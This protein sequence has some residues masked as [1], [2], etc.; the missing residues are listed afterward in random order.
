L[1]PLPQ[2]DRRDTLQQLSLKALRNRLPE[3][4]FL[5]RD[6]RIDDKGVDGALEVK[7]EYRVP[8]QGG[9]EEVRHQFTNC[10][11]QAQLKSTDKP[12]QNQDGSVSY[13]IETNNLNYLLNGPSPIYFLWIAPTDEVRYAWARDEWRRL[14]VENPEWKEQGECTVR[15]REILDARAVEAIHDRVI[16]EARL[17]RKIHETLARSS[18]AERVVV[19]INPQTLLS[20]DPQELFKWITAS[21]M[22]IVSSGYGKQVLLWL[23]VLDTARR[24][25]ARV[26]L[27]AAYAQAGLGRYHTAASH[28]AEAG[29]RRSSLSESDLRV[30]DYLR[31]VCR[32]QTGGMDRAEYVRREQG[33]AAQRTGTPAAE[34]LM[35]ALREEWLNTD[36]RQQRSELLR[37][38]RE[39]CQAIQSAPDA[40]PAQKIR[41]RL[42]MVFAEGDNLSG[43]ITHDVMLMLG[44][45]E[46]GLPAAAAA[47]QARQ[48]AAADLEH[49][50]REAQAIVRE[51][52]AEMHPLLVAE[53]MTARVTVYHALLSS[54]RMEAFVTGAAWDPPVALCNTLRDEVERAI[55]V[56]RRADNLEGQT[57][58]KLLLA[59][60]SYL[61]GNRK[62]AD[63][64]AQ[65]ALGI[66][67]AM[68]YPRLESH[69]REYT[70][71]PTNFERF[72]AT[73]SERLAQD[74]DVVRANDTDQRLLALARHTLEVMQLPEDRLPVLTRDAHSLRLI[75]R[76]RLQWC[77]HVNLKQDLTHTAIPETAY[78]TDPERFC[79]CEKH[80]YEA[81]IRHPDPQTV[82]NAFKRAYCDECSDRS[83]KDRELPPGSARQ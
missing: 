51:A 49:W 59:D 16:N 75:A 26:Q 2:G 45:Q 27:V 23:D 68:G 39:T 57:R 58:A 17:G 4:K 81:S 56:F 1:G 6:E 40:A 71:G 21:G 73:I 48:A 77:R 74:E 64:L 43:R 9:G 15:F 61:A 30:L 46:T 54:H 32:Y 65:E 78:L 52:E 44:R 72:Q 34:H 5:F 7:L 76:E 67:L 63:A 11:A 62:A 80:G 82:I 66:A 19:S 69:A 47:Q 38:M 12:K 25:D 79:V 41:A 53:A 29:T 8:K 20:D 42:N 28:L 35:E 33:R 55:E 60:L 10:R 50:E 24:R 14:D 13:A 18:M 22:T 37:Q 36:H 31:D 83:P 3:E 70:D